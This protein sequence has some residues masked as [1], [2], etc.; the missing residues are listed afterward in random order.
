MIV[1]RDCIKHICALGKHEILAGT[2]AVVL[3]PDNIRLR[4]IQHAEGTGS[5]I[6]L[7][8]TTNMS[9]SVETI[10]KKDG[11]TLLQPID[12]SDRE[13]TNKFIRDLCI[14]FTI[15][16]GAPTFTDFT[17][18]RVYTT[19]SSLCSTVPMEPDLELLTRFLDSIDAG[20]QEHLF[21]C[22]TNHWQANKARSALYAPLPAV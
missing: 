15:E 21:Q 11:F 5:D 14:E 13:W 2:L 10:S 7:T 6:L 22:M 19:V 12:Q 17:K 9:V 18:H 4:M 8:L 20:K 16:G 1:T 3:L